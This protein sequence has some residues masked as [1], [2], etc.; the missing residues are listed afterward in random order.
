M[1][2]AA[3]FLV[4]VSGKDNVGIT[5]AILETLD[6]HGAQAIDLGQSVLHGYLNLSFFCEAD[7]SLIPKLESALNTLGERLNVR[8]E[9]NTMPRPTAPSSNTQARYV[10]TALGSPISTASMATISRWASSRGFNIESIRKLSA[11]ALGCVELLLAAASSVDRARLQTEI[12]ELSRETSTDLSFQQ[13]GL[14]RRMKRLV[15]FDMDS[16]L[17]ENEVIDEF[18]RKLGRFEEVASITHDAMAGKID[19]RE[20]LRQRVALLHGLRT[21]DVDSVYRSLRMTPGAEELIRALKRLG[22]KIAVISGGFDCITDRFRSRLGLDYAFSNTLEFKDGSCTGIALPPIVDAARKAELLGVI[23]R[24]EGIDP[25]Q[26]VAIG[27]G[28]NDIPMLA[29]SGLGIAFNAKPSVRKQT[30]SAINERNLLRVL[31]LLGFEESELG[32][33]VR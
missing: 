16:T 4:H 18:A 10:L 20:A 2:A 12:F 7:P 14:F 17:I 24:T 3:P 5:A 32:E 9:L 15:V 6:S 11:N 19:F 23:A 33:I 31:F 26:I 13:E 28:A 8:T 1:S 29:A 27:D 21:K 22:Y 30:G 25:A